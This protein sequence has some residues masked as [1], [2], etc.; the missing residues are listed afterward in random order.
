M[1]L[2]EEN[3]LSIIVLYFDYL[4]QA[5]GLLNS[6]KKGLSNITSSLLL[7]RSTL[8]GCGILENAGA[9]LLNTPSFITAPPHCN[10]R[11][12]SLKH[13][14]T[15]ILNGKGYIPVINEDA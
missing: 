15:C 4:T 7:F 3:N 8:H 11:G 14:E 6:S 9:T 12:K 10:L 5:K 1:P 2:G 13:S